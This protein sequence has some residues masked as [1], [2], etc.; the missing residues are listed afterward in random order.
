MPARIFAGLLAQAFAG[1][2]GAVELETAPPYV[3][4]Q[5]DDGAIWLLSRA[6]CFSGECALEVQVIPAVDVHTIAL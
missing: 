3:I 1:Q 2:A 4:A 6:C 5:A